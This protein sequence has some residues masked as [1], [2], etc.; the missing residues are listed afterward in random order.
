MEHNLNNDNFE[1]LLRSETDEFKMQPTRKVW[2]GIYNNI[3]PSRK[4]PSIV[5]S[6]VLISSLLLLGYLNSTSNKPSANPAGTTTPQPGTI[7][8]TG[9]AMALPVPGQPLSIVD[10][11]NNTSITDP[12]TPGVQEPASVSGHSSSLITRNTLRVASHNRQGLHNQPVSNMDNNTPTR[13]LRVVQN[14]NTLATNRDIT[15][16]VIVPDNAAKI[17]LDRRNNEVS[18]TNNNNSGIASNTAAAVNEEIEG[19]TENATNTNAATPASLNMNATVTAPTRLEAAEAAKRFAPTAEDR[20]WMDEFARENKPNLR[21]WKGRL[22]AQLY[23]GSGFTY[24]S[25]INKSGF[26][27]A[28]TNTPVNRVNMNGAVTHKPGLHLEAGAALLYSVSKNLRLKAGLQVNYTSYF[29][30][31]YES[32]HPIS[33]T[34]LLKDANSRNPIPHARSTSLFNNASGTLALNSNTT[35]LSIPIGADLKLAGNDKIKWYAGA[36]L[37]PTFVLGGQNYL[38]STDHLNYVTENSLMRKFNLN[39]GVETF[40]AYKTGSYTLQLG[41]QLRYQ[42]LSTNSSLYV[43]AEKLYGFGLK[44]SVI[45]SL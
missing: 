16:P 2:H 6:L 30:Y 40:A 35:Q 1:E 20:V 34:L 21:K 29:V 36:T 31:A 9:E 24:R 17:V 23:I 26:E 13:R 44:L 22:D 11:G 8:L 12:I 38:L 33:T 5:M 25:L 39:V 7:P 4:L 3:H 37:Q 45:K 42:L 10:E 27:S 19:Q 43:N 28:N 15:T 14:N 18:A 32:T 41:P